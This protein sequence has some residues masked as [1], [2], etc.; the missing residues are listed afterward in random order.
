MLNIGNTKQKKWMR[1]LI[2]VYSKNNIIQFLLSY[3]IILIIPLVILVYG[4]Q[5]AFQ[6]V[7]TQSIQSSSFVLEQ[8]M[9]Q[10]D[11]EIKTIKAIALQTSQSETLRQLASNTVVDSDYIRQV[12]KTMEEYY[13]IM[14]YQ[15]INVIGDTYIYLKLRDKVLYDKSI[16]RA[17]IFEQYL[18]KWNLSEEEWQ[19]LY[20]NNGY[21]VP[22]FIV[23]KNQDIHYV[24]PIYKTLSDENL[25]VVVYRLDEKSIRKQLGFLDDYEKY[26]VFI[27]DRNKEVLWEEDL[28]GYKDEWQTLKLRGSGSQQVGDKQITYIT[29]PYSKWQY[30]LVL[31]QEIALSKLAMLKTTVILLIMV[32]VAFG[33]LI[34]II[35]AIRKGRP[36][37]MLV[38]LFEE[39]ADTK[40]SLED[41]GEVVTSI[42]KN[43]QSLLHELEEDKPALQ[44]TFLHNLIKA[45]FIN[46]TELEYMSK[47]AGI[48]L[49]GTK[50]CVVSFKLFAHNDFDFIDEQTL[51]EVRIISKLVM[52]HLSELYPKEVWFYK[53]NTLENIAIFVVDEVDSKLKEV[54]GATNQWLLSE[55]C[56]E[57]S[58]GISTVCKNLLDIWK[59]CEEATLAMENCQDDEHIIEYSIGLEKADEFYFPYIVE[60]KIIAGL[61]SGSI[62]AVNNMLKLLKEENFTNRFLDRPRFI[63]F[64]RR[65]LELLSNHIEGMP[66]MEEKVLWLNEVVVSYQGEY[67]EYFR[68]VEVICDELCNIEEQN[69]RVQRKST[70]NQIICYIREN[71]SDSGLG[72]GKISVE[73]DM[74]EGYL[75]SIFK[76]GAGINFGEFLEQIRIETACRLLNEEGHSISD[77]AQQVGYNSIQSFRRAFKRVMGLSPREYRDDIKENHCLDEEM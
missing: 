48:Q 32:A 15:G 44:K 12:N 3:V 7:E 23:T 19:S 75:S 31:P 65:M 2:E 46:S 37:N 63:K 13:G 71:F 45:E 64:N 5:S 22:Q 10:I 28:L 9:S 38:N 17:E 61:K 76:E 77:I 16:Y 33:F 60:E 40:V 53:R 50:Y 74:S 26:S 73:F 43:N 29:S 56:V 11:K 8:G 69:K 27:L 34:S 21:N 57:T 36:I 55:Y 20:E 18:R 58:W 66:N 6:V 49:S 24:I 30:T 68:R 52:N 1:R 4:F 62:F 59:N 39:Q 25:G 72:L 35:L 41:M 70:I 42:L 47:K 14:R 67:E 51:E 54:I